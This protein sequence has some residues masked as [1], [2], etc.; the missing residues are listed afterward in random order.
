MSLDENKAA[1]R[2][3]LTEF[4]QKGDASVLN[5]LLATDCVNHEQSVSEQRG[6]DACKQW[7]EGVRQ[8]N[9]QAFPDFDVALD[10]LI[11]EGN[12]VAK[13]WTFRGTH[14][15]EFNGIP[16]T[17]KQVT[18]R[19]ITLYRLEGGKVREMYWNYDVFGLLVQIGAIPAPGQQ[20]AGAG[21]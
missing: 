13:R 14:R 5:E 9:R 21:A 2:R 15:G 16:A 4:W 12:Q 10:D 20:P 18:M 11:A 19:G 8:A 7:A 17:G 1:V 6:R 3:I